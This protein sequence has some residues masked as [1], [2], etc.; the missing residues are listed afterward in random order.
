MRVTW[1]DNKSVLRLE[2]KEYRAGME[3]PAGKLSKA[4]IDTFLRE[5][6]IRVG[7]EPKKNT[8]TQELFGRQVETVISGNVTPDQPETA[9]EEK[10]RRG[11]KQKP[12][13]N[14]D[15]NS[16]EG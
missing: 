15:D 6:K 10:P 1:I 7:E 12:E 16:P 11:R 14:E 2:K 8:V 3:V 5:K 13:V 9:E 4:T